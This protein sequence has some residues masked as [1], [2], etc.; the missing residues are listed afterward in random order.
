MIKNAVYAQS[1]GVTSVINASAYGVIKKCF[2]C[3]EIGKVYVGLN[4]INGI[5]GDDL[6]DMDCEEPYEIDLL[7]TTPASA[8]GSCRRKLSESHEDEF[9]KIFEVFSK[10][11]I[12]YF[13]YN[14]GND[15][16]DTA[17]KIYNYSKKIGFELSVIGIPKTIDNDLYGTDH[18]PGYGSSAKY[19]ATAILEAS[20]DVKSMSADSTKVFIL[21]TMGRH[22]GWLAASASLA[23]VNAN[24]GP[25]IVLIPEVPFNREKFITK[26]DNTVRRTGYC[27]IVVAEGLNDEKGNL[28]A[29]FGATDS[30]GNKQLGGVG[31]TIS[32]IISEELKLKVHTA[33]PDYL[34]RSGGH[35]SCYTDV[36]EAVLV[37][38]MAVHYALQGK[39][40]YMVSINR[41]SDDPYYV[42]YDL[43]DLAEVA[44]NT[45]TIPN[46]FITEDGMDVTTEFIK[47]AK[48][49]IEGEYYPPILN[50]TPRYAKLRLIR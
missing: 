13:F 39:N 25:H 35:L 23:R 34:Q 41:I 24:Y 12:G 1:G 40:G 5:I 43:V 19:L 3:G 7:K 46:D 10:Y 2:S 15:S 21:E 4:G 48:P 18:S 32:S 20:L 26:V 42:T 50:G 36:N 31:S 8:F 37:G 11:N 29:H 49:L 27:S 44:N 45:K 22:A 33:V 6:A 9:K 14:G 17:N 38:S 47:Y 30:F 16:M 28:V